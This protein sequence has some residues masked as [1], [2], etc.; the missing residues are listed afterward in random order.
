MAALEGRDAAGV[1]VPAGHAVLIVDMAINTKTGDKLFMIAQSYMPAQEMHVL[2][3]DL[4]KTISP[5]Y[6]LGS[7][8]Q[9]DSPEYIF[10]W[11]ELKRF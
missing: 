11:T 9:L 5:W 4:D 2:K 10:D 7:G 1:I 6:R 8:S 3:N